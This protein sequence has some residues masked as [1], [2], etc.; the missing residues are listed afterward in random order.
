[1]TPRSTYLKRPDIGTVKWMGKIIPN[2]HLDKI[3]KDGY[4]RV[5][6]DFN[7]N[8]FSGIE[9]SVAYMVAT[10]YGRNS[11]VSTKLDGTLVG[12]PGPLDYSIKCNK[13]FND[14][15]EVISQGRHKFI[16]ESYENVVTAPTD[17]CYFD[18]PYLSSS[19]LYQGWSE[20][21]EYNLLKY[22]D[23]LNCDWAISNSLQSGNKINHIL[24]EWSKDKIVI[25]IDKKYRKW[26][27]SDGTELTTRTSKINHEVLILKR[28][29]RA[30]SGGGMELFDFQDKK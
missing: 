3:N 22:I 26:A 17:F 4:Q 5:L 29:Y 27:G 19:Y 8:K 7:S 18:P 25:N 13:K 30:T 16:C 23:N 1:V 21:D 2:L 15:V 11:S 10:I 24:K 28:N 9:K 20:S 6:S 14:H 12:G